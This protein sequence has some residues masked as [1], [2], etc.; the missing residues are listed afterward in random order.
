MTGFLGTLI[1]ALIAF[2]VGLLI[3]YLVWGNSSSNA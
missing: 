2:A 1:P 3:A